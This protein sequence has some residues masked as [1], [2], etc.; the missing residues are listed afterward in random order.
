[1]TKSKLYLYRFSANEN[2]NKTQKQLKIL[3]SKAGFEN[4]INKHDLTA[5]KTHFGERGVNTYVKPHYIEAIIRKIKSCGA[6]PFLSDTNVLYKSERDNAVDHMKLAREHGFTYENTGADIIIADGINGVNEQEIE[7]NAPLNDKVNIAREYLTANSIIVVTHVTGHLASGIGATLKNMG[8][9]MSSRKGKLVQHSVSHPNIAESKCTKC[10]TCI[11]W[12]PVDAIAM[13]EKSAH[14]DDDV[15]IGCGECLA[16]CRFDAVKFKWDSS[17]ELL[18]QQIVEHALGI[19]KAKK[20][21]MGYFTFMINMTKDCD[22]LPHP[23]EYI[24]DDIGVIAGDDPVAIDQAVWDLTNQDGKNINQH[25]YP[26]IDGEEQ[27]RYGEKI[28]L[29]SRSYEIIEI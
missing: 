3:F 6:R 16:V 24:I 7:I 13:K 17:S 26:D 20:G 1:M 18:Q 25:A 27:L 2:T 8:M 14:I 15:C 23:D 10:G 11:K 12:C 5:V 9:G 29:G 4:L 28:G 22:C 21:R 19:A